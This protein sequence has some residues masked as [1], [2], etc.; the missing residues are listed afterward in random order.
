MSLPKVE[1]F[2][3][4]MQ[5]RWNRISVE[6]AIQ[7]LR[8]KIN[9]LCH[10]GKLVLHKCLERGSDQE[11]ILSLLDYS[12]MPGRVKPFVP[13]LL[14]LLEPDKI[15]WKPATSP[16]L[17]MGVIA[18]CVEFCD[19]TVSFKLHIVFWGVLFGCTGCSPWDL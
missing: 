1:A 6:K 10:E 11:T 16:W 7:K 8:V 14:L 18:D 13:R 15:R 2:G 3:E 4:S 5:R 17:W 9:E 12:Q 19:T